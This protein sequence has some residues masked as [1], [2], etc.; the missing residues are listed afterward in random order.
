MKNLKLYIIELLLVISIIVFNVILQNNNLLSISIIVLAVITYLLFGYYRNNSYVK[1]NVIRIIIACL[2]SFFIV[3]YA[4]G[5]FVGFN[6][7]IFSF[8]LSYIARVIILEF[9]VIVAEELLRKQL[10]V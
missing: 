7:T 2:L 9:L 4:T 3:S 5:L 1:S 8:N 10:K 6:R